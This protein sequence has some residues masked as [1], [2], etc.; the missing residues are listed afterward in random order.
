[1]KAIVEERIQEL[2][3]KRQRLIDNMT[4]IDKWV[5]EREIVEI[6]KAI[7]ANQEWL[8]TLQ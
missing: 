4:S 2:K 8:K 3:A 5:T 1:M 6:D 7:Q